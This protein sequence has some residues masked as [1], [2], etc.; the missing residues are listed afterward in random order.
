M[1][2]SKGK[3]VYSPMLTFLF[4]ICFCISSVGAAPTDPFNGA[5]PAASDTA[6]DPEKYNAGD[7]G[8]SDQRG[9]ATY[10]YPVQLPPGRND[11][12]PSLL[13]RYSSQSPLRGGLA[14]GWTL[15]I[16]TIRVDRAQ[17]FEAEPIYKASLDG[18]S[19]RL[20]QVPDTTPH[21]D[22]SA[23][24]VEFDSSYARFFKWP[25]DDVVAG[26]GWLALTSD[27]VRHYFEEIFGTGIEKR[28][29][30]TR[31]EDPFG[32]TVQYNWGLVSAPTGRDGFLEQSLQSIEYTANTNAG[33]LPHARI[34]FEYAPLDTCPGSD[35]PIGGASIGDGMVEG[36]QRLNHILIDVRETQETRWKLRRRV[37]LGY[38]KRSLT[39]LIAP[40][41]RA[42][43]ASDQ[44]AG[45]EDTPIPCEQEGSPLRYL[46]SITETA[47]DANGQESSVPPITFTY[48]R[49]ALN[50]TQ[51]LPQTVTVDGYEQ[52]GRNTG[53]IG[54]VMDLDGDGLPDRASVA[55]ESG[56]CTLVWQK[57]LLGGGFEAT[58]RRSPLPTAPW[59]D[60]ATPRAQLEYCTMNGQAAYRSYEIMVD[61]QIITQIAKGFVSYHFNDYTGDGR[62]DLLTNIWAPLDPTSYLPDSSV[63]ASALSPLDTDPPTDPSAT[64]PLKMTPEIRANRLVWRVYRNVDD[65]NSLVPSGDP[66]ARFSEVFAEMTS[67][68]INPNRPF[69]PS[70]PPSASDEQID[71][72]KLPQ[73]SIPTLIDIDGD[74]FQDFVDIGEH[75]NLLGSQG[76][77]N[78]YFGNG[79]LGFEETPHSWTVPSVQLSQEGRGESTNDDGAG[80]VQQ[81]VVASLYDIN[82]DRLPDLLVQTDNQRLMTY[83][84]DGSGFSSVAV[85]M[86]LQK[87][88]EETVTHYTALA[89]GEIIDGTRAYT[90][91]LA[92]VDG[93]GLVDMLIFPGEEDVADTQPSVYYNLGDRFQPSQQL[94]E[95]WRLARRYFEAVNGSW[96]LRSDFVDSNGDGVSDLVSWAADG[97]QKTIQQ[98]GYVLP[99]RLLSKVDN[100]RGLVVDY[101]Y[102]TSTDPHLVQRQPLALDAH[103]PGPQW[104]IESVEMAAGYGTP[105]MK[106]SYSYGDPFFQS[107]HAQVELR[108][109]ST[110]LGFRITTVTT[111]TDDDVDLKQ[112]VRT[113]A[114]DETGDPNGLLVAEAIYIGT[115]GAFALHN[116]TTSRWEQQPIFNGEVVAA[117]RVESITRTCTADA[118]D[119]Q[120]M[121][122][123]DDLLRTTETWE[124]YQD[125][126]QDLLYIRTSMLESSGLVTEMGDRRTDERYEIR[127]GLPT[128]GAYDYRMLPSRSEQFEAVQSGGTVDFQLRTRDL[129]IFDPAT[130]LPIRTQ[131]W[132][133]ETTIADTVRSYDA[134]TGN[135]LTRTKPQQVANGGPAETYTYD[136]HQLFLAQTTNEKGHQRMATYDVAT[137][138]LVEQ[139]GPNKVIKDGV[140]HWQRETWTVDGFGRMIEHAVSIDGG[141]A[142]PPY[143]LHTITK[144]SYYDFEAPSR[145]RVETLHDFDGKLWITSDRTADGLGRVLTDTEHLAGGAMAITQYGYDSAGNRS[146]I[147]MPD[148]RTDDGSTVSF[149]YQHDG[150]G[151]VVNFTQPDGL[152]MSI[153]YDGLNRTAEQVT[154]D[155]SG[156]TTLETMDVFGRLVEVQESNSETGAATTSYFYDL[157]DRLSGIVDADG[158]R[159]DLVHD[160]AGNRI[161]V[162][163]GSRVWRYRYDLN[164]NMLAK[165]SP[166]PAGADESIYS[167]TSLYDE[168]D[169]ITSLTYAEPIVDSLPSG[170]ST[171]DPVALTPADQSNQLYM[172]LMANPVDGVSQQAVNVSPAMTAATAEQRLRTILYSYDEG[173]NGVGQ[174][175][176]VELPF[177]EIRY[178]Y[179]PR[180]LVVK[181]EQDIRLP[182]PIAQLA[183]SQVVQRQ[184][185][186]QNQPTVSTWEDGQQYRVNYDER[187]LPQGVEW[188]DPGTK[189]WQDVVKYTRSLAGAPRIRESAFAAQQ[190][191]FTYDSLGRVTADGI[192]ASGTTIANR[193]YAFDQS[194]NLTTVSGA[195]NGIS[196]AASFTYDQQHR[197]RT[198]SGPNGY[199]GIF[200]Y[201]P[202]GNIQSA[203]VS[204]TGS[205]ESR[206]VRYEYGDVDPQAVDRLVDVAS[207]KDYG[208]FGYDLAGNMLTRGT[209]NGNL[210]MNWDSTDRIRLVQGANGVELYYYDHTGTRILAVNKDAVRFWFAE[211]ETYYDL[212]GTQTRRYL[213]LSDTNSTVARV[214]NG[215]TIEIQYADALQNLMLS[216]DAQGNEVASFFYGAF[217][218]V[219]Q[220]IGAA[221]HR[222]QFNGKER[223]AIS[224]LRY[225]GFRYYD[226]LTLNWNSSDPLYRFAPEV[227]LSE[228]QRLNLYAF[229]LQNPNRYYDPDGRE[230][231]VKSGFFN[232]RK[233]GSIVKAGRIIGNSTDAFNRGLRGQRADPNKRGKQGNLYSNLQ[234]FAA[235]R[236]LYN[237]QLDTISGVDQGVPKP[238]GKSQKNLLIRAFEL[239]EK[240]QQDNKAL[241]E[242]KKEIE[243]TTSQDVF[244]SAKTTSEN[245]ENYNAMVNYI[246]DLQNELQ[247]LRRLQSL[248]QDK[249]IRELTSGDKE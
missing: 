237:K 159:T 207:G 45:D 81:A 79:A 17:G 181:E 52:Y 105:T 118:T 132:Q 160:W 194:G 12:V 211:S 20:I 116:Y 54:R 229:S 128:Y 75:A 104:L 247:E 240:I 224:G 95:S 199:S 1:F 245:W 176:Q 214:E 29:Y 124:P 68:L 15:D 143:V 156:A 67:P 100:G 163:R 161:E 226:P 59:V 167:V 40:S 31:Q 44:D 99:P 33:L 127:Y 170:G 114:Y 88:L 182:D 193:S 107:A 234:D 150:L 200:T 55:E 115:E 69:M 186:P 70:L 138:S 4:I 109:P 145:L 36:A 62:L 184:F 230:P 233:P 16:P 80:V 236:S 35:V 166:M 228:P 89:S 50:P 220:E 216:L 204:W 102:G 171:E 148:P 149:L 212:K 162:A 164:D 21:P 153:S 168:L 18:V 183:V 73:S 47:W 185:N 19:G 42:S 238:Q 129:N 172:P 179:D 30:L 11:M 87:P 175:T 158:N 136:V 225:Y 14:A 133:N 22:L 121:T 86:G 74:G 189:A 122:Q 142:E 39:D 111:E 27:G 34:T 218:E 78:V 7:W 219:V 23:F 72:S 126:G 246:A 101:H 241:N 227:G 147:T 187:G 173:V 28:W 139:K 84:N 144:Q 49:K 243:E 135:L 82:G 8:V 140:T 157:A 192:E 117:H 180:G 63:K 51:Q 221:N 61:G 108:E 208:Q 92:D 155:G 90:R 235:L 203:D 134:A 152:E 32:N 37:S 3:I 232:V 53:A 5:L 249:A 213:H 217:G 174:L 91:R 197:V 64:P 10:T 242:I 198:A 123:V 24:R 191:T 6:S 43:N 131:Q 209:P 248:Q 77:W 196:A 188:F 38:D 202:A 206:Q 177:G 66:N 119:V 130:G 151:R 215:T 169:R 141:R 83:R 106:M 71:E 205:T 112:V 210:E 97:S 223:D 56:T 125:G 13:L 94:S 76:Q 244:N 165:I 57:G 25:E 222:R 146:I 48:N 9:A 110:F 85:D 93:D 65:P 26:T 137:G 190:R 178:G 41:N 154:T 120:C 239:K 46:N 231:E 60:G 2:G 96:S 195:T 201:S 113:Y 98:T 58:E 103:L